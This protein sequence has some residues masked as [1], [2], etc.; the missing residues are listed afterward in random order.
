MV[1]LTWHRFVFDYK[2]SVVD[3][4]EAEITITDLEYTEDGTVKSP[5]VTT[6]PADLNYILTFNGD[7]DAP[8]AIGEYTVV[9]TIEEQNYSGMKEATLVIKA[10]LGVEFETELQIY[11]YPNPASDQLKIVVEN[12]TVSQAILYDMNGS[13]VKQFALSSY[14]NQV[15]VS[16]LRSGIYF[17]EMYDEKSETLKRKKIVI[18]R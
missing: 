9:V 18:G 5:T 13:K 7:A 10:I 8:S 1:L 2:R 11:I 6:I 16:S 17:L 14:H 4:A 12:G 3:K 15:N